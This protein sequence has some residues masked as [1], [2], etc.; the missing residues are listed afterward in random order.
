MSPEREREAITAARHAARANSRWYHTIDLAPGV[1]TPGQIDLR[2][3]AP[4][5]L[6]P[7][8]KGKRG[9]DVGTFDGFWAFEL[10]KRGAEVV[11]TDTATL[12]KNDWPSIN[13]ARLERQLAA[14]GLE[15]GLGFRLAADT[16]GSEVRRVVC[17]VYDLSVET[18]GGPVDFAFCGALL[19]HLRDPIRALERIRS[20]VRP[21][22]TLVLLE[23]FSWRAS[24]AA[25][26]RPVAE[27][28]SLSTNFV[29]WYPNLATL[30]AW[31]LAAGFVDV[32]RPSVHR[33]RGSADLRQWF[34]RV[35]ARRPADEEV[36][37]SGRRAG[38]PAAWRSPARLLARRRQDG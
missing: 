35:V 34:C 36:V 24:I 18:I 4:K 10:E 19:L 38:L 5:V 17:D 16:L 14:L 21:G 1:T 26:R 37:T 32:R 9:L 28:R 25:P 30:R 6:P 29:W 2:D 33:P 3:V 13:R 22:G 20:V 8:L 7:D 31:A 23:P 12:D 11:A 27:F 15:L